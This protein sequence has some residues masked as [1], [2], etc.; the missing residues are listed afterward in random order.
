MQSSIQLRSTYAKVVAGHIPFAP[1]KNKTRNINANFHIRKWP[2]F[3]HFSYFSCMKHLLMHRQAYACLFI[4]FSLLFFRLQTYKYA[5][6][7]FMCLVVR[8]HQANF[9]KIFHVS[10]VL[11]QRV[12]AS[13]T[14]KL[15]M[16][17][18]RKSDV[19]K[20]RNTWKTFESIGYKL[21]QSYQRIRA[22]R[23]EKSEE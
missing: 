8:V 6:N 18:L 14:F 17:K 5:F 23:E 3:S 20:K 13:V 12:D 16:C 19:R 10:K 1:I 2:Y 15:K 7:L 4:A 11:Q 22:G 21:L 9:R